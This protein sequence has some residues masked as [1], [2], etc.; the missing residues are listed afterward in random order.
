[1]ILIQFFGLKSLSRTYP[2]NEVRRD[3]HDMKL[4]YPDNEFVG[5]CMT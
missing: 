1:M 4:K 5:I 3:L 2:D